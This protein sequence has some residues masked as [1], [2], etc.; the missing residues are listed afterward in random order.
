MQKNIGKYSKLA[1]RIVLIAWVPFVLGGW[2]KGKASGE[3]N[4]PL[5]LSN[6]GMSFVNG[7]SQALSENLRNH[8]QQ[9]RK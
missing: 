6:A 1:I 8:R 4:Q 3:L 7:C 9:N 2:E 5:N